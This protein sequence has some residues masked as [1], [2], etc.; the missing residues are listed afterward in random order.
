MTVSIRDA[1]AEHGA[2]PL[3]EATMCELEAVVYDE[4]EI[5]VGRRLEAMCS[6]AQLEEFD[7]LDDEEAI[8]QFFASNIPGYRGIVEQELESL[9]RA[10]VQRL[11]E[12]DEQALAS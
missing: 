7:S 3:G 8:S 2:P 9:V 6:P 5:R 1:L 10:T 12:L 11:S 4:L